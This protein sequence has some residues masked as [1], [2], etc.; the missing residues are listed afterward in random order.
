MPHFL[1]F[2][3]EQGMLDFEGWECCKGRDF[4]TSICCCVMSWCFVVS[5]SRCHIHILSLTSLKKINFQVWVLETD[6][7]PKAWWFCNYRCTL[8][9]DGHFLD[10][11]VGGEAELISLL[12]RS[13]FRHWDCRTNAPRI[14]PKRQDI[15]LLQD[16]QSKISAYSFAYGFLHVVFFS[17][18]ENTFS[19]IHRKRKMFIENGNNIIKFTK[20]ISISR[21]RKFTR[22]WKIIYEFSLVNRDWSFESIPSPAHPVNSTT[23]LREN[24]LFIYSTPP[25]QS[26][27]WLTLISSPLTISWRCCCRFCFGNLTFHIIISA[28]MTITNDFTCMM[29]CECS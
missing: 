23:N 17:S 24:W 15:R 16:R 1:L 8:A 11:F 9:F 13:F 5:A 27:G 7:R 19:L 18:S 28:P 22:G 26:S 20:R 12:L 29:F 2:I 6:M 25:P 4:E 21:W 14:F 10:G 3:I